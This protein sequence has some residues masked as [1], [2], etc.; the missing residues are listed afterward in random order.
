MRCVI[1]VK[2][3]SSIS[4]KGEG[5]NAVRFLF[6]GERLRETQTPGDLDMEDGDAID[7]QIEQV[8]RRVR[9]EPRLHNRAASVRAPNRAHATRSQVGGGGSP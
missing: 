1:T 5:M 6:D 8:D 3:G 7:V 2:L 9:L 4:L